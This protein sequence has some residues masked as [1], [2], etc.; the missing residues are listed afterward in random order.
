MNKKNKKKFLS[1][2][3]LIYGYLSKK[4]K[5]QLFFLL[6]SSFMT[7][8]AEIFSL[9]SFYP[10]LSVLSDIKIAQEIPI[11]K[12]Y[13]SYYGITKET[14]LLFHITLIFCIAIVL[15]AFLRLLNLWIGLRVSAL[16]GNDI[17]KLAYR[18]TLYQNYEIHINRNT[19]NLISALTKEIDRTTTSLNALVQ[20]FT[21]LLIFFSIL[22]FILVV[23]WKIALITT[24]TVGSIYIL[25]ALNLSKILRN[26][27]KELVNLNFSIIKEAKEALSSIRDVILERTQDFYINNFSKMDKRLKFTLASNEFF[28]VFPRFSIEA[29]ALVTISLIAFSLATDPINKLTVF[30]VLGALALGSQRL[31]PSIQ[32]VYMNWSIIRSCES[33]VKTIIDLLNQSISEH[34][35]DTSK[36]YKIKKDLVLKNI[37][38]SYKGMQNKALSE[39][40]LTIKKG[41]KVGIIGESGSGKSTLLDIIMGL[42]TPTK[43]GIYLDGFELHS[44]K[45]KSL[46]LEWRSGLSHVPQNIYLS[47][48][49]FEQNIALGIPTENINQKRLITAAKRAQLLKFI[50]SLENSFKTNIGEDGVKL[51]G[52]QRQRIGIARALYKNSNFLILDEAT[53]ALDSKTEEALMKTIDQFSKDITII[54]VAHRLTSLKNCNRII[55]LEKGKITSI[56]KPEEYIN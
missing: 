34:K 39:I 37:S 40:N 24:F 54:I 45:E 10:F 14:S 36:R 44:K 30:P 19:S 31:L 9:A 18:K 20:G 29:L 50:Y 48:S 13:F 25:L 27:S 53:S 41:E 7:A 56:G 33:S 22:T 11:L 21:A 4:R 1:Q 28:G 32:Q 52:G 38:F 2:L 42:L 43:G 8:A 35:L 3:F 6:I 17:S 15:S 23:N 26:N 49:D 55:C 16:I 47:D 12:Y 5:L 46:L 51:S